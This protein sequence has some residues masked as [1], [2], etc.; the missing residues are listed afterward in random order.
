MSKHT[1]NPRL[2]VLLLIIVAAAAMRIPNAAQITPWSNF[3]PI[4]AMALF[5]GA[6][7]TSR[8]KALLF[9]LLTLL[10]GDL[11]ISLFVFQG[12]YGVLYG[13]WYFVYA[14]FL[15]IVV[16]GRVLIRKVTVTNVL[17]AGV[18]ASLLHW[19]LADLMV[20]IG[21]GT[22]LRTG[23]RLSRDL[24]GLLQCYAQGFP[25][26]KNFLAGTLVYSGVMFGL[27]EWMKRVNPALQ[28]TISNQ[29]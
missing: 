28:P 15:L 10:L 17:L 2:T 11:A 26:M 19:G 16:L 24:P 8:W 25:F 1:F 18:S 21:G 12:K 7:F 14:I 27:F 6:Y 5:G 4:G 22:D 13:G 20:W 29:S 23:Q 3:S 9:P